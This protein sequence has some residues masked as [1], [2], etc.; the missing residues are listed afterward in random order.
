MVYNRFFFKTLLRVLL[1]VGVA[2]TMAFLFPRPDLLFTQIILVVVLLVQVVELVVFVNTTNYDLSRFIS[3]FKDGDYTIN[4]N[5]ADQTKSFQSLHRSFNDLAVL[6]K[7]LEMTNAAQAHFLDRLVDQIEFG[8]I[9][10]DTADNLVIINQ[11]AQEFLQLPKIRQ[12][13]NIQ[14]PNKKFLQVVLALEDVKSQLVE[15][16]IGGQ[17]RFFSINLTTQKL[18][19]QEVRICSFQ[20][21]RSEIQN[22]EMQAWQKLVRILTHETM[23]SVTPLISLTETVK[24]ILQT[25]SGKPKS[26]AQITQEELTDINEALSTIKERGDGILSFVNNYRK[27]ARVPAPE[28]SAASIKPVVDGVLRLMHSDLSAHHIDYSYDGLD[29]HLLIDKA[30]IE[31]VIINLLKNAIEVVASLP[32]P[33]I[34]INSVVE[35]RSYKLSISDNGPGV[36]Q[37]E[38]DKIFVPFFTT[39]EE[40]SGI[41]LS[42]SRQMINQ[43]GG[44]LDLGHSSQPTTFTITLP[45]P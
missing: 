45:I 5:Q 1:I 3:S 35:S 29:C 38:Q 28:F 2:S 10:F 20:D 36:P 32:K 31:Q 22:K 25:Q 24:M 4:F 14:N 19:N 18:R 21:I 12:W 40:G 9:V 23:N 34:H 11:K 26:P 15:T 30:Q 41:G 17:E 27:L 33:T 37:H 44:S 16:S 39:K 7:D 13:R 42:I 8:I 43:H 6:Y